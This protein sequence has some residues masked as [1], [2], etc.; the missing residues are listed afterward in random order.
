MTQPTPTFPLIRNM[1][2]FEGQTLEDVASQLQR[3]SP[4]GEWP[5]T[6]KDDLEF[7][8]NDPFYSNITE[9]EKVFLLSLAGIDNEV[10][11]TILSE[12]LFQLAFD[13]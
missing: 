2:Q 13:N 1:E 8:F 9:S 5:I 10:Y 7:L 3:P 6:T 11:D 4:Y 12:A